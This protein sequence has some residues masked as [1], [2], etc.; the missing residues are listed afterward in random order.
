MNVSNAAIHAI[1]RNTGMIDI[2]LEVCYCSILPA[3]LKQIKE[4]MPLKLYDT[5][6]MLHAAGRLNQQRASLAVEPCLLDPVYVPLHSTTPGLE[7]GR[8]DQYLQ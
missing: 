5:I 3:C 2:H 1:C 4:S 6:C 7:P 8:L